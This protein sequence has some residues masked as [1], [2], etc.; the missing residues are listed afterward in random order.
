MRI[1]SACL[2]LAL[3]GAPLS[4]ALAGDA[5]FDCGAAASAA[6]KG[7]CASPGLATLD[8]VLGGIYDRAEAA[9]GAPASLAADQKAWLTARDDCWSAGAPELCAKQ[10]YVRR[11]AALVRAVPAARGD[12]PVVGPVGI[13]CE[14]IADPLAAVFVNTEPG[15][16]SLAW[17]DMDLVLDQTASGSGAR[18]SDEDNGGHYVFWEK[19]GE[20]TFEG[21]ALMAPAP[22]A[23]G[24]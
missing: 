20:A 7:I 22:C 2:A 23:L 18:Y 17:G 11:I 24:K 19:G 6:E 14:T 4:H 16:L 15:Y 21:P 5:S 13:S 10:A 12:A 1:R 8:G 9:P 3:A